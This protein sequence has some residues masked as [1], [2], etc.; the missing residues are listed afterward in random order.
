[1]TMKEAIRTPYKVPLGLSN[2]SIIKERAAIFSFPSFEP[3]I[4]EYVHKVLRIWRAKIGIRCM[5]NGGLW[6]REWLPIEH[7]L[8]RKTRQTSQIS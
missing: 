8:A 6:G 4:L 1:M 7:F 5:H 3:T 2:K